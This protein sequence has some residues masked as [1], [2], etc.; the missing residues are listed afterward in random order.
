MSKL[1]NLRVEIDQVDR[2]LTKLFE[3]RLALTA[4]VGEYKR[5]HNLPVLDAKR[6]QQVLETKRS[7]VTNAENQAA[8]ADLFE[9]IMAIS[10]RQQR[11]APVKN[12]SEAV[13]LPCKIR[14]PIAEP[15]VCHQ[16]EPGAYGEEAAV[17][18]FGKTVYLSRVKTF[19]DVFLAL[20]QGEADYGVLPMENNSTGAITAVYDLFSQ[21]GCY[22]VGEQIVPVQHCLMA[23][24]GST[25]ENIREVYS[26]EQG[27]FQSKVFLKQKTDW[28]LHP[29]ENTA[30]A[31]KL[32][33][34]SNDLSKAAIGSPRAAKLYGLSILASEINDAEGN[35]T[36]FVILS[37]EPEHRDGSNKMSALFTVP[38][39]SGSLNQILT[40]LAS[41][42]LNMMKLESRP[43]LNRPWEYLFF[44][45][46][47]GDWNMPYVQAAMEELSALSSLQILGNY[48]GAIEQG[49][50]KR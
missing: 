17:R 7:L 22:I 15:K 24:K 3:Q 44:V 37:K 39:K 33:A 47:S 1:D 40:V 34:A 20:R 41:Y 25:I 13:P 28:Q 29:V 32:V 45:D 18:F 35:G 5:N 14:F 11:I 49:G 27:F 12:V 2:E 4:Q 26:H 38:H 48:K 30:A 50:R 23:P 42:G 46:F 16:G 10:R 21:Y 19:E 9:A 8:V 31:A 6:E 43:I 36:R